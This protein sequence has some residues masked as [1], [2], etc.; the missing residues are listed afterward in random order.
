MTR[1]IVVDPITRLEGHGKIDIFL[2]DEGNVDRAYFQVPELRG[3][4]KFA[5]GRPAED[6]PQITSRI[7][8]VCPTA[9]HMAATKALDDLY[10]VDPPSAAKKI[11]E[12]I[13]STFYVEDHALHFFFLGGPDFV[14]GP[15]APKAERNILGVLGKVGLEIGREVIGVRKQLRD[16]ISLAGGKVIH[17]VFGLPG[18]ISKPLRKEDQEKFIAGADRAVKFGLFSL[19]IF[20]D[21]VLK[22]K[23]YVEAITSDMYTHKTYYMGLVDDKNRVNFYDGKLRVVKPDGKEFL[24][25]N[26]QEY[27]KHVA[28]HVEPWSYIKFCYLK[29]VGWK[30]FSEGSESGVYAVAPLARLNAAEGMATPKAQEAYEQFYKRLGG[31]PVHHTLANH[32]ARLIEL[33]YAAERMQELAN[34]LEMVSPDVRTIP[35]ERPKEGI[36]VVEAPRGTLFHHYQTDE[37]GL[38]TKANL[39]VATQNNAARIAMSVDKAARGVIKNGTVDDGI[40]NLIEMGFRAY[41][42]CHGCATHALPGQMPLMVRV[43]DR[44]HRLVK[45]VRRD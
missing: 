5:E 22:N 17:P 45:E 15:T 11:R 10:K 19:Q 14:V 21:V 25:F 1:K 35:T 42:P 20:N 43:Y 23:Q 32:W 40:L 3:F 41:D 44:E 12:L 26:A 33:L 2:N 16:L 8:G 7:C 37:R 27:L 6:M 13:Y 4:E 18:G 30:G 24:K 36:G 38:I 39:I 29:D 34:D 9:H 28:E 31:R